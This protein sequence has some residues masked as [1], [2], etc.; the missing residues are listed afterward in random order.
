MD[1]LADKVA[2]VPDFAAE[3]GAPAKKQRQA[4]KLLILRFKLNAPLPGYHVLS[5]RPDQDLASNSSGLHLSGTT[6]P[7]SSSKGSRGRGRGRSR[8]RG[9]MRLVAPDSR[10]GQV[11]DEEDEAEAAHSRPNS[12][13]AKVA[14]AHT[15]SR[16]KS[17]ADTIDIAMPQAQMSDSELVSRGTKPQDPE[18][19]VSSVDLLKI[20]Q[21]Q[22][23]MCVPGHE[24]VDSVDTASSL[25]QPA[26]A[27]ALTKQQ[28]ADLPSVAAATT[29]KRSE[30]FA[31]EDDYDADD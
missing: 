11:K 25:E 26:Q 30:T 27:F 5:C 17:E 16:I 1:F 28:A 6:S 24:Q 22:P 13:P 21:E 7:P 20:K 8:G 31:E 10:V 23:A 2:A 15:A 4:T 18:T 29:L 3:E 19:V 14:D 9:S 12:T